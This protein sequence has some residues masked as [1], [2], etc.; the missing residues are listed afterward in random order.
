MKL[1]AMYH[2]TFKE[3]ISHGRYETNG[4]IKNEWTNEQRNSQTKCENLR[5]KKTETRQG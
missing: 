3:S 2:E 1:Q 5:K 4:Q